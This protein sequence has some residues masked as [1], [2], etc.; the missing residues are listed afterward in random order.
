MRKVLSRSRS[1]NVRNKDA[2][3]Q[4]LRAAP[5]GTPAYGV[6]RWPD[7]NTGFLISKCGRK[8]WTSLIVVD[9]GVGFMGAE[10]CIVVFCAR[11]CLITFQS[12][13]T[14]PE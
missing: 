12:G 10:V 5:C 1:I 11:V 9:G 8:L 7:S 3:Q 2:E 4:R 13:R 6:M 14:L